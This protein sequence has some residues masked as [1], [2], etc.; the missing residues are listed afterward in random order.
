MVQCCDISQGI[1]ITC[2]NITY[3]I[4]SSTFSKYG[5]SYNENYCKSTNIQN[6]AFM[7]QK[8]NSGELGYK[9]HIINAFLNMTM[10]SICDHV[11]DLSFAF[12]DKCLYD[13]HSLRDL[14]VSVKRS[15]FTRLSVYHCPIT[16]C[17][18]CV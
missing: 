1:V 10:L 15:C 16:Y 11:I 3:V 13:I 12:H 14:A 18:D 6:H 2:N 4:A 9:W 8:N 5:Y 17:R 7:I